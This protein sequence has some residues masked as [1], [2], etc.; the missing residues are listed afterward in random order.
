[1]R[2]LDPRIHLLREMDCRVKPGNDGEWYLVGAH[3][4]PIEIALVLEVLQ[5]LEH[6]G[7]VAAGAVAREQQEL[8][9]Q[10]G[11]IERLLR[12]A[13]EAGDRTREDAAV[14]QGDGDDGGERGG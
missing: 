13:L 10:L 1:M 14:L 4:D 5:A 3:A 12:R 11:A 7:H 9:P 8:L 6:G 2:G